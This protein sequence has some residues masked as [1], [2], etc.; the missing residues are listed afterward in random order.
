MAKIAI[1]TQTYNAQS[2]IDAT[3]KSVLNQTFTDFDYF[4]VDDNSNDRTRAHISKFKKR[5]SRI[6]NIF[7]DKDTNGRITNPMD[8]WNLDKTTFYNGIQQMIADTDAE[9]FCILDH[10]DLYDKDFIQCMYAFSEEQGLDMA[11][12]GTRFFQ[13]SINNTVGY[14]SIQEENDLIIEGENWDSQ[15]PNY[16]QFMRTNWAKLYSRT[17]FAQAEFSAPVDTVFTFSV[18]MNCRKVGISRKVLHSY[19]INTTG[20]TYVINDLKTKTDALIYRYTLL[21]LIQKTGNVSAGNMTFLQAVHANNLSDSI[22]II[23]LGGYHS[24]DDAFLKTIGYL[25]KLFFEKPNDIL[26][27]YRI[28]PDELVKKVLEPVIKYLNGVEDRLYENNDAFLLKKKITDFSALA[29]E[30]STIMQ[31]KK[32]ALYDIMEWLSEQNIGV[33]K[34]CDLLNQIFADSEFAIDL[35]GLPEERPLLRR[36][37]LVFA[38]DSKMFLEHRYDSFITMLLSGIS[39][40]NNYLLLSGILNE[41]NTLGWGASILVELLKK[42]IWVTKIFEQTNWRDELKSHKDAVIKVLEGHYISAAQEMSHIEKKQ[43][44]IFAEKELIQREKEKQF[45]LRSI[46]NATDNGDDADTLLEKGLKKNYLDRE[47][48]QYALLNDNNTGRK[49]R[50]MN[51]SMM[52][53][54]IYNADP[55][56]LYMASLAFEYLSAVDL[57]IECLE[58]ALNAA[59][60]NEQ[61]ESIMLELEHLKVKA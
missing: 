51:F 44:N 54:S 2:F 31:C 46:S 60:G 59:E 7:V 24:L 19:R 1:Y 32:A 42:D 15:F 10:D 21:F 55:Q 50:L 48:M 14:R 12:C 6:K 4:I 18:L 58:R 3:I 47:L 28:I 49:E 33:M 22:N 61:I 53:R 36:I 16:H 23:L 56:L 34:F 29:K 38:V 35:A 52:I 37:G 30:R 5:D 43:L 13:R 27:R 39:S 40:N 8:G 9:W 25:S 17:V 41:D 57:A 20:S 26:L 45:L 11:C